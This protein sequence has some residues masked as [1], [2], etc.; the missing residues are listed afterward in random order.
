MK[1][2]AVSDT[3]T[4]HRLLNIEECDLFIFAGDFEIRELPD[5]LEMKD[6]LLS[7][8][9]KDRVVIFGNHDFTDHL[10]T[11][12]IREIFGNKIHYLCNDTIKIKG[13]QIFGSSYSPIFN[14]WAWMMGEEGL[15][16]IWKKIP[17]DVDIIVTHTMPYGILDQVLPRMQSVGSFSLTKQIKKIQ[18]KIQIGGH[19]HESFGRYTDY[20][21]DYYNVSVLDECYKLTNPLTKIEI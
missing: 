14:D 20:R 13:M 9:A 5:L 8:K 17:K 21:T 16:Q 19:L 12:R 3:H 2:I 7:I 15:E 11:T 18:P 10:A 1:I 6:W 4:Q